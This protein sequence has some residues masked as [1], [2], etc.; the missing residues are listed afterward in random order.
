MTDDIRVLIESLRRGQFQDPSEQISLLA[1]ALREDP[2]TDTTF[3]IT[4]LKAPQVPLRLA[5]LD[6]C[7]DTRDTALLSQIVILASDQDPRVRLKLAR[8]VPTLPDSTTGTVLTRLLKDSEAGIRQE[9]LKAS[10]GVANHVARQAELLKDDD[11]WSVRLA[12]ASA[13]GQQADLSL[14]V[15]VLLQSLADDDDDDVQRR[16]AELV[17]QALAKNA[18]TAEQRLP[19][20]LD[21]LNR[22]GQAIQELGAKHF[23]LL[24]RWISTHTAAR[25]NLKVLSEFGTDLTT[26]AEADELPRA[27]GLEPVILRILQMLQQE[28]P[29]PVALLGESGTGKSAIVNELVYALAKP[30][31]GSWRVLRLS[32]ADFM[33]GTR[34]VGEWETRVQ[35]LVEAVRKPRRVLLYV[36]NLGDLVSMGKW[37]KSDYNVALALAPVLED[38]TVALLGE[39]TPTEFERGLGTAAALRR[40]IQPLLVSE[41]DEPT[42]RAILTHISQELE[43]PIA[44][45]VLDLVLELSGF[46][47]S[48]YARPGNAAGLLRTILAEQPPNHPTPTARDVLKAL[49]RSTGIPVDLLDDEQPLRTEPVREF[50]DRRILG[51]PEAV[52]TVLDLIQLIKAGLTDPRKPYGVFLFIGPTGV[53][54]TELARALAEYIFGDASRLIRFD[55]SEYASYEGFQRLIGDDSNPGR[56]TDAVRRQPFSILLLDEI[57]KSHLN[58]FDLCLQVF[59]AGRLTDKRGRTVDFRRTIIILTSN[60]GALAPT[61]VMGFREAPPTT[62]DAERDRVEREISRFFRPEFLN[63]LD[64]VV[65]FRP[66]TLEVA[67]RIAR[68]EVQTV[69][70]RR[71]VIRRQVRVEVDPAALSLLVREGYSA[72]FGARPLKRTVERLLLQPLARLIA[73]GR[74]GPGALVRLEV[75]GRTVVPRRVESGLP[76]QAHS[77]RSRKEPEFHSLKTLTRRSHAQESAVAALTKR[78]NDLLLRTHTPEFQR[79]PDARAAVLD[80]IHRLDQFLAHEAQV[81]AAVSRLCE[82]VDS[83]RPPSDSFVAERV[84][85]LEEELARLEHVARCPELETMGDALVALRLVDRRGTPRDSLQRLAEIYLAVAH[86]RQLETEVLGERFEGKDD[87][88]WL[89]IH[90]LGAFALFAPETGLHQF[91]HRHRARSTRGGRERLKEDR[92]IVRVEVFPT[93]GDPPRPFTTPLKLTVRPLKPAKARLLSRLNLQVTAFDPKSLRSLD[94]W[95]QGPRAEAIART[96]R[97]L[98]DLVRDHA[99]VS[100]GKPTSIVRSYDTGSAPRVKDL[101]SGR[102][103]SRTDLIFKGRLELVWEREW[104]TNAATP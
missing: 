99:S 61:P 57:E 100:V 81:S 79:D 48:H 23:P 73:E 45:D 8:L 49:A 22:A 19:N 11:S 95:M 91:D 14:V 78:K 92:E 98:F 27:Y 84:R 26:K 7:R 31:N 69:L 24:Q 29:R 102:S 15:D 36:P 58:V 71:G 54:K 83:P 17:E 16:S 42:T 70:E 90:G 20:D 38:G 76:R 34:Y 37:A 47:L 30:E 93:C 60:L 82:R 50:F 9:A 6:L 89:Q 52:Q 43:T 104:S 77:E 40:L 97:L 55:M 103:T 67:E 86:R 3:L 2:A 64:R 66:L 68:R 39:C 53:G 62:H 72:H 88:A 5:A 12:A 51:Q 59:D 4:L 74:L 18:R 101:R 44:E 75:E 87:L 35:R 65:H 96:Q 41:A 25:A 1:A 28:R 80:D 56:L 63:R 46:F 13:L 33:V 10:A 94:L 21:L 32:P 85:E